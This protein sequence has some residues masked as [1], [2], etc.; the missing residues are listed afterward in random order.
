MLHSAETFSL[1]KCLMIIDTL[2]CTCSVDFFSC[3]DL[4]S[5]SSVSLCC[6]QVAASNSGILQREGSLQLTKIASFGGIRARC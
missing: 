3:D 5:G 6:T 4:A 2:L 1:R